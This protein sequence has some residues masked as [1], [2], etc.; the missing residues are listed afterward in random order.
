MNPPEPTA[1]ETTWGRYIAQQWEVYPNGFEHRLPDGA[2]VDIL[3]DS[4]AWEI[5]WCKSG[6]NYEA[7]GQA[8]YYRQSTN[9]AGGVIL[10]MGV[11][12]LKQEIVHYLRAL[13]ACTEANLRI[14]TVDVRDGSISTHG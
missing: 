14:C 3:T 7:I 5:D 6:K 9:R 4:V 10:L 12:P 2:R 1:N 8:I 13:V 11:K